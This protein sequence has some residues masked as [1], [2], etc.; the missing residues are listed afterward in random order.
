MFV[1]RHYPFWFQGF[2]WSYR[3][4]LWMAAWAALVT[5]VHVFLEVE[6]LVLPGLPITVLG[7][8]VSFYLGF[9]GN[10]AYERLWE[11]RKIWGGI[12]NSSR[13]W[14]VQ[15]VT[16]ITDDE[17]D[18]PAETPL[19]DVHRELIYRHVAWLAALRIQLRRI[20]SWE[21]D[22]EHARSARAFHGTLD[23]SDE[24]IAQE[25]GPFVSEAEVDAL[26]KQRNRATQ[27]VRIQGERLR[28]LWADKRIDDFRHIEMINLLEELYT[29][30]GKCERIKN[31]PLP[32]QYATAN[33]WF[34]NTFLVL[35][36]FAMLG[37]FHLEGLPEH[38]VWFTVPATGILGW[39]FNSWD[40]VVDYSENPFE[41]MVNDIPMTAL[42]RTIEIDLRE[43][44]GE[45]DLPPAIQ[46]NGRGA[47][48]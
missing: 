6:W 9:K 35:L 30:Q 42:S 44:L 2:L 8:A 23:T 33:R 46:P 47:L 34:V 3:S 32:R 28:E 22:T 5:G 48:M 12:V 38:Y 45:T 11:A 27:L 21:H 4:L 24:R 25:I 10:A 36:P 43:M 37:A 1:G 7:T 18:T 13:T 31:F 26:M 17:R 40:A 19:A 20:K 29:L 16:L 14:G 15:V 39:V 41:G